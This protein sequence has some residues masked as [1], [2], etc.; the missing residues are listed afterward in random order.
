MK[1]VTSV[2]LAA[3]ASN[4]LNDMLMITS[5]KSGF[6]VA[7]SYASGLVLGCRIDLTICKLRLG[8][9]I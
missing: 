1:P 6:T 2:K 9:T 3:I 4:C 8:G 5:C 7:F